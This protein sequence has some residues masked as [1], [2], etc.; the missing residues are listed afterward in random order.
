MPDCGIF[1][2]FGKK[3]EAAEL[4]Y[5]GLFALQHRGQES[6]GIVSSDGNN[7][8]LHRE[9]GLI[10]SFKRSDINGLPGS[11]AIGHIRYSTSGLSRI[12]EAQ[13]FLIT[14]NG[15][16]KIALVHNGNIVVMYLPGESFFSVA[17]SYD[18]K[19]IEDSSIKN[20]ILATPTTFIALL[21]A[22]AYGWRQE[23]LTKN[24]QKISELGRELYERINGLVKHFSDIGG[25]INKAIDAYNIVASSMETRV[26]PS[27]R[28]FKELGVAGSGEI[29]GLKEIN[30]RAK[31]LA[32]IEPSGNA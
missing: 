32:L 26:L 27:A 5:L 13:P 21:K 14:Y 18:N 23:E 4:T 15:G 6:C 7:L 1:G 31:G 17:L 28:K 19:L 9:L 2:V 10:S 20:V 25:A 12:E 29:L 24:A 8:Y 11:M 30:K 22:I 16:T 3:V